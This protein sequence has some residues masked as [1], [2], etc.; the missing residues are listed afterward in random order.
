M[1]FKVNS[2][3]VL[4]ALAAGVTAGIDKITAATAW[5][6]LLMPLPIFSMLGPALVA[7]TAHMMHTPTMVSEN[8]ART[9]LGL[10]ERRENEYGESEKTDEGRNP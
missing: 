1:R 5:S 4:L 10:T 7:A 8:K 2:T 6:D 9:L 3:T